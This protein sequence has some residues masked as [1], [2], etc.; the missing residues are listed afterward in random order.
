MSNDPFHYPS[1]LLG[2]LIDT[3]PR[4]VRS[5]LDVLDFFRSA[6]VPEPM[7]ADLRRQVAADRGSISKY[8]IART[9]LNRLNQDGDRSLGPRREVVRRV[10]EFEAFSTCWSEDQLTAKGLVADVRSLVNTKDSFTRMRQEQERERA[11]RLWQQREAAEAL[12]RQRAEREALRQRLAGLASM[13]NAHQ[14]GIAFEKLLNEL[15]ALDGLRV[16]ESFTV[17]EDG[18]VVEQ[19]DGLIELAGQQYL[20]EAK[21]W[22]APLG[23]GVTAQHLVRVHNRADVRGLYISASGYTH[24]AIS[25][26]VEALASKVVVLAEIHELLFLLEQQGNIADWLAAKAR[27]A[28]VDRVPL[29]RPSVQ[30]AAS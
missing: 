3:I 23:P 29:F 8:A 4:L 14:R 18:E 13:T 17:K 11:E 24:G 12:Q 7:T 20:V 2:L 5:K 9:V 15:F 28:A 27:A 30:A 19:I 6:G 21:W 22:N 26:C 25:Q 10:C 16:R 1:E